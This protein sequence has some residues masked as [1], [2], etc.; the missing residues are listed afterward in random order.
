MLE[1]LHYKMLRNLM[2]VF[3]FSLD[4]RIHSHCYLFHIY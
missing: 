2:V 3:L 1:E 4:K